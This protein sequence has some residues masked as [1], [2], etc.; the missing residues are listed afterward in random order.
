M[1]HSK[2][3][4]DIKL[5]TKQLEEEKE[6]TQ[7]L[8][9]QLHEKTDRLESGEARHNETEETLRTQLADCQNMLKEY[10]NNQSQQKAENEGVVS[11]KLKKSEAEIKSMKAH[12]DELEGKVKESYEA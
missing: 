9:L 11:H 4:A 6:R 12:I 10:Q 7:D 2:Y 1:A 5:L 8:E 3:E